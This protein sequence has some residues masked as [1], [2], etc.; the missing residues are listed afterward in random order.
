MKQF[1]FSVKR[2]PELMMALGKIRLMSE[3]K[4]LRKGIFQVYCANGSRREMAFVTGVL[5]KEFPQM[6]VVGMSTGSE[7]G[8]TE[9]G[10]GSMG[11]SAIVF[12][13]DETEAEIVT[14]DCN[15]MTEAE[16]SEKLS[17]V[18]DT[19]E[20]VRAVQ[21]FMTPMT[22]RHP[23]DFFDGLRVREDVVYTGAGAGAAM[24]RGGK[25]DFFIAYEGNILDAGF[26][27]VIY[28]GK[29]LTACGNWAMS[30]TPMGREHV[31]TKMSG[32][33]LVS[34]ID[35]RPAW[36]LYY[37][38][39]GVQPDEHF[40]DNIGAFP[41]IVDREGYPVARGVFWLE[42]D[43]SL[44]VPGDI[45]EGESVRLSI[46]ML[47]EIF[48]DSEEAALRIDNF[49]ADVVLM[50]L[51]DSRSNFLKNYQYDEQKFVKELFPEAATA[52][53][54]GE[55]MSLR[56]RVV[57]LNSAMVGLCLREDLGYAL[58]KSFVG[59]RFSSLAGH[60]QSRDYSNTLQSRML[61][62]I[63]TSTD[64]YVRLRE[65]EKELQ[66][67]DEIEI[68]KAANEAKSVFLSNMSHEIRTPINA[69]LGMN[70]MI[71]RE[72]ESPNIREYA[73][74]IRSAGNQ[75]LGL[76]NDILDFSK[77]EAGKMEIIEGEY[78][79]SSLL[80]DMMVMLSGKAEAKGLKLEIQADPATPDALFGDEIRIRQVLTNIIN[81]AVK[82]TEKGGIQIVL[83]FKAAEEGCIDLEFHVKD[84]GI[85]IKNT[86]I[87]RLTRPFERIEEERN[88]TIEGTGL[89]MSITT[90]L[91]SMMGSRL[92]VSSVYGRGSDFW[93]VLRQKVTNNEG[94]GDFALRARQHNNERR[95]VSEVLYAPEARIL[96]VDDTPMNLTVMSNLLKRTGICVELADS[97]VEAV[98]KAENEPYDVIFMDH[99]MP[100][101]DGSEAMRR[102][103]DVSRGGVNEGTPVIVLTANAVSGAKE[104]FLKEG[105]DGYLSKPVDVDEL[106]E[107][108]WVNIPEEKRQR[109][110]PGDLPATGHV[111]ES[112]AAAEESPI[113]GWL[114][115]L[116]CLDVDM[117]IGYCGDEENF[118]S[119]I[120]VFFENIDDTRRVIEESFGNR[121]W[122]NYNIK[123]H[124][125]K[126]S[127]RLI[128]HGEL[129]GMAAE[130]EAAS[131]KG[132]EDLERIEGL[133]PVLLEKYDEIRRMLA[134]LGQGED[135]SETAG[136]QPDSRSPV[137]DEIME[138]AFDA[139]RELSVMFDDES[140]KMVLD[141][142][143]E[144][145]LPPEAQKAVDE[146]RKALGSF[147][148]DL[149]N[150]ILDERA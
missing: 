56:G 150:R 57:L 6:K 128:G 145:L 140:V 25:P 92:E 53:A 116:S 134:P 7:N 107:V 44:M 106:E 142:M 102:I 147:D 103:K 112:G 101:M 23:N 66:L 138:E 98:R 49:G 34:E 88:R 55:I 90:Q 94:I 73:E 135:P 28:R 82:Y 52:T 74:N 75:L 11:I 71:L 132:S 96:V 59:R 47:N 89:G 146:I 139:I 20:D 97:G 127:S 61:N 70:E 40:A 108:L 131:M 43:R 24:N 51:C 67:R 30:W 31:I 45:H 124:A 41:L 91:L 37:N 64:E 62:F 105:F 137:D 133:T 77:I 111:T 19:T 148:W 12:E 33:N 39:L 38:Y 63:K 68:Q 80:N 104:A 2:F 95:S 8:N 32:D 93:F 4:G 69:V 79:L 54:F 123:V 114:R 76:I 16:A 46:G 26:A 84:T 27:A 78:S 143:E 86:D 81:N 117:G 99:R 87:I 100:G 9:E 13:D 129:S 110:N 109:M 119:V 10:H 144:Y 14:Y 15:V 83:S 17:E 5:K 18:V 85:G 130:L 122:E 36:E 65:Q 121:D 48:R 35:G 21:L 136:D 50:F 60:D 126:S 58:P 118:M 1:T 115:E 29:K 120:R 42:D 125:L 22:L 3:L 149:V 141:S 113:P 72:T